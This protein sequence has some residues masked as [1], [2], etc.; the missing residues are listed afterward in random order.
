MIGY[1]HATKAETV[2]ST[3]PARV[4]L[5]LGAFPKDVLSL[6]TKYDV[7]T[8]ALNG[9]SFGGGLR[10]STSARFVADQNV[11]TR[12]PAY[13]TVDLLAQYRFRIANRAIVAQANVRNALDEDYREGSFGAWADP[14]SFLLSLS[15]KF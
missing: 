3:T 13:R 12:M 15:T 9:W 8:G 5:P 10:D 7:R 4:G 11:V 6:W 14:R 1:A 2:T